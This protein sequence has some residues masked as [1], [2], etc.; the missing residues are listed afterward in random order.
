M[1]KPTLFLLLFTS[2]FS[3]RWFEINMRVTSSSALVPFECFAS[4][5]ACFIGLWKRS[6]VLSISA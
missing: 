2:P 6:T 4:L 5:A 3:N 1:N